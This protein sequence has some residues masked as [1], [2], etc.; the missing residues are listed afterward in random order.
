MEKN[1]KPIK[2][3]M[4]PGTYYVWVGG[5]C[6]YGS[7]ARESGGAYIAERDG[8]VMFSESVA[9]RGTTEFRMIFAAMLKAMQNIAAGARIVFITN[10][11][12]IRDS[13]Q[14]DCSEGA[15][16]L[17]LIQ[18]CRRAMAIFESVAVK[19]VAFHKYERLVQAHR[20]AHL[21]MKELK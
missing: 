21:A 11:A 12:Y 9:D 5:S 14:R 16:N 8:S 17:D 6:D 19:V 7:A 1:S 10:V 4:E 2:M 15:A 3:K 18:A 20:M 13:L